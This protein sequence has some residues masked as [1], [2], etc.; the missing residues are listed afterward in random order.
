MKLLLA[1]VSTKAFVLMEIMAVEAQRSIRSDI[2][3]G[4]GSRELIAR[5]SMHF[6]QLGR[7]VNGGVAKIDGGAAGLV[8]GGMSSAEVIGSVLL[9]MYNTEYRF[10][11]SGR[12]M[13]ITHCCFENPPVPLP[14]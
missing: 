5:W 12:G 3:V 1:P 13:L 7:W 9:S 11:L 10:L 6:S 2:A 8:G 14:L 4:V